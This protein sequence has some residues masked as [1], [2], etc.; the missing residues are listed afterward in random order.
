MNQGQTG[1]SASGD[2]LSCNAEQVLPRLLYVGDVPVSNSFGGATLLFRLLRNYPAERL[3]V[4]APVSRMTEPLPGVRYVSFDAHW[5]RLFRTRLS[6][7]YCAWIA[8]RL[9]S[10]PRWSLDLV[11]DFRPTAI[12]TI[13][14]TCGWMLGWRLA[15]REKLPLFMLAHDDHVFYRHLPRSMW[16]WAQRSFADACRYATSRFCISELMA[17][18]YQIRY[19]L[20]FDTQFPSRD[21]QNPVFKD[22][23]PQASAIRPSLTFAFAGSVY[24]EAAVRQ[25]VAFAATAADRG[26]RLIVFS[27]QYAELLKSAAIAKGLDSRSPIASAE[28][29]ACLRRE[30]DCLLVIGSF[31]PAHRDQVSTLFPSKVAD[32]SAVGLP[33]LAWAPDYASIA[34]FSRKHAGCMELVTDPDPTALA[35]AME[36]LASSPELRT[37]Y[38]KEM[39]RLGMEMFS[40]DSAWQKFSAHLC[41]VTTGGDAR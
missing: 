1:A 17:R 28:L 4:C 37:E 12:L 10:I 27:P 13:S 15:Q 8:W 21:P 14:Q 35:P 7:L 11:R 41:S 19:G 39:L 30:A 29:A 20:P 9:D 25:I 6:A 22:P 26:H 38:A 24:G 18:E 40:P 23:A 2:S 5:P 31:D 34:D 33:I 3:V 16:P 36:R 32:Y